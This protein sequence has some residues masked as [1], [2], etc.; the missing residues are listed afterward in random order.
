MKNSGVEQ[1]LDN[2]PASGAVG[3][4]GFGAR[5]GTLIFITFEYFFPE[6]E[7]CPLEHAD[8]ENFRILNAI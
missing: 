7:D 8:V 2:V 1:S 4:V 3:L 5:G 6:V